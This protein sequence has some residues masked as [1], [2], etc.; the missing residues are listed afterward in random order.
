[1]K[2]T[3][4]EKMEHWTELL[5]QQQ[6]SGLT[7]AAFCRQQEI[8]AWKFYYWRKRLAPTADGF[9]VISCN[10]PND[11]GVRLGRN[12]WDIAVSKDFDAQTL[13]RVITLMQCSA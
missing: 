4:D 8:Q 9:A 1:M 7:I 3:P 12:G 5:A 6:S 13:Q 10:A 11:S 2:M